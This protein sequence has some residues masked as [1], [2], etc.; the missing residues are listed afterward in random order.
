M[1][2]ILLLPFLLCS[3]NCF[4]QNYIDNYL[5]GTPTYTT[6]ASPAQGIGQPRDLDFK[7]NTNELW[8]A[9]K[10]D[11]N[12][13]S[14][15][16]IFN[17]GQ[18]NQSSQH[19]K[20]SHSSHFKINVTGIAFGTHGDWGSTNE[21]KNTAAPSSTFMGP[22]L[23]SSDTSIFARVFQ[24]NWLPDRP[25][26]SHLDML[27]QSPFAMGIAHDSGNRYWVSDGHNGN[28]CKYD[29][30]ADHSPGYDDHAN[31]KI[32]RYTDVPLTRQVDVP[33]HMIKD[34]AT[35]WL[36][37]IDA[38]TKKLKRVNTSTGNITGTLTVPSTSAELLAG[39]WSVTGAQVQVLDSFL[40][41]QPCG[42]DLYNGRLIVGDY[43][44]GAI[45]VYN[46]T[47][48]SPVK[49]G[50]IATGQTGITGL[51]IGPDGRIWFV[52]YTSSTVVR[53]NPA[54]IPNNDASIEQ[55][56]APLLNNAEADF[57]HTAFNQ[58]SPTIAPVFTLKNTGANTLSA[59]TIIYW[60]DNG[61]P[62]T[63]SW[64]GSL[65]PGLTASV[66]LPSLLV[67]DGRHK[68]TITS[69]MP[70]GNPDSNPAN[71]RKEGAFRTRFP[72]VGFPFAE[73][74]TSP[75]FPPTGWSYVHYNFNNQISHENSVGSYGAN[76]GSLVM[77]NYS[78]VEN[79]VGQKDYLMLPNINMTSASSAASLRFDLAYARYD[80][81]SNDG[82][83]VKVST[84]CGSTWTQVFNQSGVNLS[85][86]PAS[87]SA[88]FPSAT[89]WKSESVPLS[90]YAGQAAMM[91]MFE[92]TSD[93]GNNL[94]LDNINV[95]S[96][97]GIEEITA[98]QV[99]VF[100][101]PTTG[102]LTITLRNISDPVTISVSDIVGRK[103]M[104]SEHSM[105]GRHDID[106]SG[107]ANGTYFL[108]ISTANKSY[109][110]KVIVMK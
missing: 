39:Y 25:L 43:N 89:Q 106:L 35:G 107:E 63:Y 26:G 33:G 80:N 90:A 20:D 32:W 50:T 99:S 110:E 44:T 87:A 95:A 59:A 91:L 84:D 64:S 27:H 42:I 12:G 45:H 49:M 52:N 46:I 48:P 96:T 81:S 15:V 7:P 23:W 108:T 86:A 24:N 29:F 94:Y 58:C 34:M 104:D 1:N 67:G 28:L 71:D 101:N 102:K 68:L 13:S 56:T 38:G 105:N 8:V 36:Y 18:S 2:K 14:M 5:S 73:H 9:N 22:A 16:I 74:F 70:N 53:I 10:G 47:G 60:I 77:D 31:G 55:I 75:T 61:A 76:N 57:Y 72:V 54:T 78:E 85:T 103:I 92:F 6:I 30:G 88:F 98:D 79:I 40:T 41:S 4:A 17:A 37:I 62:T 11:A 100:P 93:H 82:L 69:S 21:I 65:A 109:Q 51:K 19:R 3:G 66:T 97:V 83:A